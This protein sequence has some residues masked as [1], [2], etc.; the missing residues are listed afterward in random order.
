MKRKEPQTLIEAA[1][2]LGDALRDLWRVAFVPPATRVLDWLT[3]HLP[4]G[5]GWSRFG[6]FTDR[7]LPLVWVGLSAW[8]SALVVI[9]LWRVLRGE[10]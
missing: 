10:G 6:R 1:T 3:R 7:A 8:A 5:P 4:S 2:D 9:V